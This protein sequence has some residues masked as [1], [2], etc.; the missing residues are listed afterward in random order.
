MFHKVT[1]IY[2]AMKWVFVHRGSW[3]ILLV[4]YVV[5]RQGHLNVERNV[6][7]A[8]C[9]SSSGDEVD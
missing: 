3:M 4:C 6:S 1:S 7:T 9:K 5:S 8:Y 2:F